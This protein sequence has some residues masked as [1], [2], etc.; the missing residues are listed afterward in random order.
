MQQHQILFS[1][2]LSS[3][4]APGSRSCIRT[5]ACQRLGLNNK[6]VSNRKYLWRA[7][8]AEGC[9]RLVVLVDVHPTWYSLETLLCVSCPHQTG[10]HMAAS[11][12]GQCNASYW[13]SGTTKNANPRWMTRQ[14]QVCTGIGLRGDWASGD[15]CIGSMCCKPGQDCQLP[16]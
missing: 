3:S 2:T 5:N 4:R 6:Y 11:S 10:T 14:M 8:S 7:L 12:T 1:H 9:T 13:T 16:S 15:T